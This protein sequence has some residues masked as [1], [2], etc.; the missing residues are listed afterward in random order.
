MVFHFV[1][2]RD[3]TWCCG[4]GG[5][6]KG[7]NYDLEVEIAMDKV[8]QANEVGAEMV[9][10]A[11]PSCKRN[12]ID[13]HVFSGW[14]IIVRTTLQ[15]HMNPLHIYCRLREIGTPKRVAAHFGL[16]Y[17]RSIFRFIVAP[18]LSKTNF[19]RER[20]LPRRNH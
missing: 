13:E 1:R 17:E 8:E 10:S 5:G 4:G 18:L 7:I 16:C 15:H 20:V 19:L 6:V 2:N 3:R 11:F 9:V 12:I 14:S